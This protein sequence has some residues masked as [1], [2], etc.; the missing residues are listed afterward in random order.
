MTH[1]KKTSFEN[2]ISFLQK[3]YAILFA[4]LQILEENFEKVDQNDENQLYEINEKVID[5]LGLV[6]AYS[7]RFNNLWII[8]TKKIKSRYQSINKTFF[9]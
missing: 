5:L 7:I 4:K 3:D 1:N 9:N 6:N 8:Y 2:E